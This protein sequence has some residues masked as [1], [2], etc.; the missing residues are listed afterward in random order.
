MIADTS[1]FNVIS[2]CRY[3]KPAI[4]STDGASDGLE[5]SSNPRTKNRA[6]RPGEE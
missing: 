2:S 3:G 4:S 6:P 1:N 5:P